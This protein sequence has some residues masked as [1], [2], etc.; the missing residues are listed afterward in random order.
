MNRGI[1]RQLWY[2]LTHTHKTASY[3]AERMSNFILRDILGGGTDGDSEIAC[4]VYCEEL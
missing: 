1:H 2:F 4:I 3:P